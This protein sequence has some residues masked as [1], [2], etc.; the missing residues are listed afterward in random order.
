MIGLAAV[1]FAAGMAKTEPENVT[2]S[3]I[4]SPSMIPTGNANTSIPASPTSRKNI[5]ITATQQSNKIDTTPLPPT[6][7][8]NAQIQLVGPPPDSSFY[9][10]DPVSTI[11]T[12]P[13]PQETGQQFA[14]YLV[15]DENE[16]LAG[17]VK[18]PSLGDYGYQLTYFPG[19]VV[20]SE[21]TYLLQ[22][23]LQQIT[24][25]KELATSIPRKLTFSTSS[26]R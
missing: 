17:T 3:I 23:R 16:F 10:D 6:P 20:D 11:W 15:T 14:I 4:P 8:A 12:W 5:I 13:L 25:Q 1:Y 7:P 2:I 26:P 18:D 24:S 19:D 9:L 22:I 21:G